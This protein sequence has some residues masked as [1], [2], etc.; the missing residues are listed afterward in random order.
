MYTP[1]QYVEQFHLLFLDQL[2]RKVDK[3]LYALK[4]GC[5]LRFFFGSLRYS[6]DMDLDVSASLGREVLREKVDSI[7]GS[8]PFGEVLRAR[9]LGIARSSVPKQTD[10]TQRWKLT[11]S[12]AGGEV[13]MP[14]K[15]EFS[16]RNMGEDVRFEPVDPAVIAG[17]RLNPIM[18]NHYSAE[19]ACRQKIGALMSRRETQA[20]DV[21]DLGLLTRSGIDVGRLRQELQPQLESIQDKLMGVSFEVF[22]SQVLAFLPPDRQDQYDS[23]EVWDRMVLEIVEKLEGKRGSG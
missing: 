8:K 1:R 10:T 11:L 16:R 19:A 9:G 5:N 22:R 4:G 14:T 6:E 18:A 7:L 21:F 15:V 3:K 13:A 17:Y 23:A 20:R 2:G 12:A